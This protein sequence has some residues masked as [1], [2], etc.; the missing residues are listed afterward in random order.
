[1]RELIVPS[2]VLL[3][4]VTMLTTTTTTNTSHAMTDDNPLVADWEGPYGGV[5]PFDRVQIALFKPALEAAMTEQ[6]AETDRST[7][8]C[9]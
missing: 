1:M 5:P 2:I 3:I 8:A 9:S 7:N 4:A 6:L